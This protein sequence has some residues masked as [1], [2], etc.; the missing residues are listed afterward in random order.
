MPTTSFTVRA[1]ISVPINMQLLTDLDG[2]GEAESGINLSAV[3]HVSFVLIN[4][5]TGGT[6]IYSSLGAKATILPGNNGSVQFIPSGTTDLALTETG[7]INIYRGYWWVYPTS[8]TQY[9]VPEEFEMTIRV[10]P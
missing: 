9:S 8:A 4:S 2:D 10:R 6:V 3:D 5:D 7:S 1:G